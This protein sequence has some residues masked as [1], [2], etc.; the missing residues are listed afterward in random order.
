MNPLRNFDLRTSSELATLLELQGRAVKDAIDGSDKELQI[1]SDHIRKC[2]REQVVATRE[3]LENLRRVGDALKLYS[4]EVSKT[5]RD[6][7]M[8]VAADLSKIAVDISQLHF[9]ASEKGVL[10]D[11]LELISG[12]ERVIQT[13]RDPK[14]T[15][16]LEALLK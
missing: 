6:C 8:N 13:A 5:V 11:A 15:A 3:E 14:M 9:I 16:L 12:L 10:L 1:L 4:V 7:R 2:I